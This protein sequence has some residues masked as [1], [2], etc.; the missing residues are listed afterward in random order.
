[1]SEADID[2]ATADAAALLLTPAGHAELERLRAVRPDLAGRL[3]AVSA[4]LI[5]LAS[6]PVI[7]DRFGDRGEL[8]S[9]PSK[10]NSVALRT[11]GTE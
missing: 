8:R 7:P 10:L 3:A 2:R 9:T 11:F 4:E 6:G 5:G 1:M